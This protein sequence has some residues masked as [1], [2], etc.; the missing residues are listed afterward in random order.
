M[1]TSSTNGIISSDGRGVNLLHS[2]NALNNVCQDPP[3]NAFSPLFLHRAAVIAQAPAVLKRWKTQEVLQE[4]K[5][6]KQQENSCN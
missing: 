5:K 4:K 6:K 2:S 3:V 1:L